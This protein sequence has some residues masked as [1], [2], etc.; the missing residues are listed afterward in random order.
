MSKQVKDLIT[1]ELSG[2]FADLDGVGVISPRGIDGNKN[3]AIRRRLLEKGLKMTVVKNTLARRGVEGK[4][5]QGFDKLLDGPSAVV[6]GPSISI[7]NVARVLLDEQKNDGAIELRGMFFDGEAYVGLDGVKQRQHLPHPRRSD[8]QPGG[9]SAR[10][11]SQT[12]RGNQRA[13]RNARR[14][15]QDDRRKRRQS[16]RRAG[17][18]GDACPRAGGLSRERRDSNEATKNTKEHEE[19]RIEIRI[20]GI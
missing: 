8:R 2:K 4:R 19:E 16:R 20:R 10:P 11:G 13:G 5:L 18:H 6:Y 14:D 15:A 9:P 1:K 12:G 7:S 17:G 3:N